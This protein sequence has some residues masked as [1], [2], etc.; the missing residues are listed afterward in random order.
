MPNLRVK[1]L[2]DSYLRQESSGS[3]EIDALLTQL[4]EYPGGMY[5]P[6]KTKLYQTLGG[7][8]LPGIRLGDSEDVGRTFEL[9][10]NGEITQ[11]QWDQ[12]TDEFV[13]SRKVNR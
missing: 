1:R 6:G 2:I 8:V 9:L 12:Y 3:P 5:A 11:D 4:K 10:M 7:Q 13:A